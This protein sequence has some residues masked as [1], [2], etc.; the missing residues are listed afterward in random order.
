MPR[1]SVDLLIEPHE[2]RGAW[3]IGGDPGIAHLIG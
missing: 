2:M 3:V 1:Q